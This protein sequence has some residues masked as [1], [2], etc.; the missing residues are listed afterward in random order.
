MCS[1]NAQVEQSVRPSRR[2]LLDV[3]HMMHLLAV[4]NI[5][6]QAASIFSRNA[7]KRVGSIFLSLAHRVYF[8]LALTSKTNMA[9][10]CGMTRRAPRWLQHPPAPPKRMQLR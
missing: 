6:V 3:R 5:K 10:Q 2:R 8:S 9:Q 4:D 7:P 1:N